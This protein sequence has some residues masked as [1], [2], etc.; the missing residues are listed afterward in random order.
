MNM[1]TEKSEEMERTR[2]TSFMWRGWVWITYTFEMQN[3]RKDGQ[4]NLSTT[5]W[6]QINE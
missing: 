5:K 4:N 1:R 3:G 2:K 6:L